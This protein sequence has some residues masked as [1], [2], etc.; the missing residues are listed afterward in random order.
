M[1]LSKH[2][3]LITAAEIAQERYERACILRQ[4]QRA[5]ERHE[6]L[7]KAKHDLLAWEVAHCS[8]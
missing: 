7:V 6:A 2:I 1:K 5:A 4:S 3:I 8:A